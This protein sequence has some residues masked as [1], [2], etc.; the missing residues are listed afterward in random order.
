M[1]VTNPHPLLPQITNHTSNTV[2]FL[3]ANLSGRIKFRS[4]PHQNL[5][6][7]EI[8]YR[9]KRSGF[10]SVPLPGIFTDDTVSPRNDNR[11]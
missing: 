9:D 5:L 10:V 11:K 6:Y 4:Y 3:P 1:H 2:S 8:I 7:R